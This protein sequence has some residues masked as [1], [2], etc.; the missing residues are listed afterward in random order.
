MSI[1]TIL[2]M[3]LGFMNMSHA[4]KTQ[5]CTQNVTDHFVIN[6]VKKKKKLISS[7]YSC[8]QNNKGF[9][10][11]GWNDSKEVEQD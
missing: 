8:W 10:G 9:N 11:R 7:S 5:F 4:C 2:G 3:K 6:L 1:M